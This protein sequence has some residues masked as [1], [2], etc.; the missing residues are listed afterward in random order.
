MYN[1]EPIPTLVAVTSNDKE[2]IYNKKMPH[3]KDGILDLIDAVV[4]YFNGRMLT[5]KTMSLMMDLMY[6]E[7]K[8]QKFDI[9]TV[10][11]IQADFIPTND[12]NDGRFYLQVEWYTGKKLVEYPEI[13]ERESAFI[14]YPRKPYVCQHEGCD[15]ETSRNQKF[16][17]E[18]C[19]WMNT[20]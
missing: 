2:F 4:A 18:Q 14:I 6:K 19:I 10:N 1:D 13:P 11:K 9:M 12:K 7:L 17:S 16:C 15:T 8:N 5:R 3:T 20:P